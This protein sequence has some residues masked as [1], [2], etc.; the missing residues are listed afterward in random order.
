ML[1]MPR[2]GSESPPYNLARALVRCVTLNRV[3][4][5]TL[6]SPLGA[7]PE[8]SNSKK[9]WKVGTLAYSTAGLVLLFVWLIGGDFGY[10]LKERSMRPSLQVILKNYGVSDF[11]LGL[12]LMSLPYAIMLVVAPVVSY[13]S[14]RH[15]GR[16][17]RRIPYLF[18]PTPIA[19][20]SMVGLAYSP[21]IGRWLHR[22]LGDWSPGES[23]S[24]VT[25]FGL[26]WALFDICTVVC[27]S[28]FYGLI[29]DVVPRAVMGRFFAL[30]RIF[31]LGA[32]MLFT[33]FL[34]G[35][36]EAHTVPIFIGIGLV[37]LVIFSLMCLYVKEGEYPPPPP[38]PPGQRSTVLGAVRTY[39]HDC[40]ANSYYIY[41]FLSIALVWVAFTPYNLF[42]FAYAKSVKLD[43]DTVG[44]FMAL[45]LLLS[46]LQAFPAGWLVDKFHALRVTIAVLMLYTVVSLVAFFVVRDGPT[47]LFFLV[48]FGTITG[49]WLTVSNPLGPVLFPRLKYAT[50]DSARVG[51]Y[52]LG[53]ML[54]GP[55][56]GAILDRLGHRYEYVFLW[57]FAFNV[58]AL[59]CL[60]IVYRK[61]KEYG[62]LKHYIAPEDFPKPDSSS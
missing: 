52:S 14:D 46:L 45:Q 3:V 23:I 62:G 24:I 15:R 30:F 41:L 53:I 42:V 60:F 11:T 10:E 1:P 19:F 50:F 27:Q 20:L 36:I 18:I 6:L 35:K 38:P 44:K 4:I 61:F 39:F 17:G 51:C 22:A 37:Y 55:V 54:A 56:C 59:G 25:S 58:L 28:A 13:F 33:Y 8:S 34:L 47:F 29:N 12:L 57:A 49:L 26:F 48:L 7:V 9:P 31:S 43:L 21:V 5:K 2:R 40:F 16:W 32:G